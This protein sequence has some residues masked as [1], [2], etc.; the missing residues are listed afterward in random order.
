VKKFM[1]SAN[2]I[3]AKLPTV[4]F[5]VVFLSGVDLLT[6]GWGVTMSFVKDSNDAVPTFNAWLW[7]LAAAH[8]F[9]L[10]GFMTAKI[11]GNTNA[12]PPLDTPLDTPPAP[13]PVAVT[14]TT[15]TTTVPPLG[16]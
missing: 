4:P 8:G 2:A 12:P 16:G 11:K 1:A 7:W 5:R 6:L 9:S 10:G 3:L 13:V 14:Q 15:T